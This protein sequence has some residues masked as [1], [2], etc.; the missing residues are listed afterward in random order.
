MKRVTYIFSFFYLISY[1]LKH[2]GVYIPFYSDYFI[3]LIC[4][5]IVLGWIKI[6]TDK[7]S[8]QNF[9]WGILPIAIAVVYFTI[10]FEF[11]MPNVSN[12]YTQDYLDIL[13]YSLGG[14]IFYFLIK[15]S[16]TT[17]QR[18]ANY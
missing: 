12:N 10:V 11:I 3:D 7:F 8:I 6:F 13:F 18:Q 14:M 2:S 4:I 1:S 17:S 15:D 5:P 9:Q 16:L